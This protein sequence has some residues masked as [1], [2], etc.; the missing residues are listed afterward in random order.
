MV[1]SLVIPMNPVLDN[2]HRS[3]G[4][5]HGKHMYFVS[6]AKVLRASG[7]FEDKLS[8]AIKSCIVNLKEKI[9]AK[10]LAIDVP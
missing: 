1:L 10:V 2:S 4:K 3:E 7:T 6:K 5:M 9:E 8:V